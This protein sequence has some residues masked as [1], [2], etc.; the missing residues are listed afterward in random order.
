MAPTT[1]ARTTSFTIVTAGSAEPLGE[2]NIDSTT[3]EPNSAIEHA[4]TTNVPARVSRT[5]ASLSTGHT[6]PS[7]VDDRMIATN[8]GSITTSSAPSGSAST[9]PIDERRAEADEAEPQRPAAE[10]GEVE[11][12]PGEEQ[13]E[14][15]AELGEHLD[16]RVVA[17]P[18]RGP[19]GR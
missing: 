8:S 15:H 13:Q 7:D 9:R 3:I 6:M 14:R 2:K 16:D 17:R 11:L 4:A 18:S 12:E 19:R 5:P 10:L 1:I